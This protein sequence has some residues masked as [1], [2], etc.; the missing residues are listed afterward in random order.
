MDFVVAPSPQAPNAAWTFTSC[1][2]IHS[3]FCL[4]RKDAASAREIGLDDLTAPETT[5]RGPEVWPLADVGHVYR[6]LIRRSVHD[7]MERDRRDRDPRPTRAGQHGTQE[8]TADAA[9]SELTGF[10]ALMHR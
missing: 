3:I 5:D 1:L 9:G 8:T 2:S 6:S 7:A 4:S 10:L